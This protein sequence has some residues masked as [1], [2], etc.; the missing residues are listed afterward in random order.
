MLW[1]RIC[2]IDIEWTRRGGNEISFVN[3]IYPEKVSRG[4]EKLFMPFIT[5]CVGCLAWWLVCSSGDET[6]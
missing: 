4:N 5:E 1:L 6:G 3:L 2:D